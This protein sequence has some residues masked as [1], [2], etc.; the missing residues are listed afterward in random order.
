MAPH[1]L[2]ILWLHFLQ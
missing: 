1:W 2:N